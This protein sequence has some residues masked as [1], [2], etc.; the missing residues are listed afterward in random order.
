MH[1]L[2]KVREE[3]KVEA[4]A[5]E[6]NRV[7]AQHQ[8]QRIISWSVIGLMLLIAAISNIIYRRISRDKK[9]IS[10]QKAVLEE[11]LLE[12]ET[13]I[14]EVHHRV[15]NNLQIISGLLKKQ[16]MKTTHETTRKLL[17]EGQNRVFSMALV[18]QNLYQSENLSAVDI[19]QYFLA[20]AQN[21]Q[22]S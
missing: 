11:A 22:K 17:R 3:Y 21:I 20:L 18:H 14:K 5:T 19:Q 10:T 4:Y 6:L 15:K 13:L 1:E 7:G 9:L 2:D 16:S 8:Q 12:K